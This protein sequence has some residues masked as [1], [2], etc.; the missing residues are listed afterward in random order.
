M[1]FKILKRQPMKLLALFLFWG[2]LAAA[3]LFFAL[4][5]WTDMRN[6]AYVKEY[7]AC[8]GTLIGKETLEDGSGRDKGALLPIKK[9]AVELLSQSDYVSRLDIRATRSAYCPELRNISGMFYGWD[10]E[11]LVILEGTVM[12]YDANEFEGMLHIRMSLEDPV[13]HSAHSEWKEHI[14]EEVPVKY[15][16]PLNEEI[17]FEPGDRLLIFGKMGLQETTGLTTYAVSI[18]HADSTFPQYKDQLAVVDQ[19]WYARALTKLERNA[20]PE[21]VQ[22]V[23]RDHGFEPFIKDAEILDHVFTVHMVSDMKLLLPITNNEMFYT[24][25]RGITPNDAGKK[26][27]VINNELAQRHSLQVGDSISLGLAEGCY[28][29]GEYLSGYPTLGCTLTM[30]YGDAQAYEIIG[31]YNFTE[32]NYS[33]DPFQYSY[34]GIF[35]PSAKDAPLAVEE[36]RPYTM[37]FQVPGENYD[38][39]LDITAPELEKLGYTVRL[40]NSKWLSV[41]TIYKNMEERRVGMLIAAVSTFLVCCTMYTLLLGTSYKKEF[42]LRKLL[43]TDSKKARRAYSVPFAL[44]TMLGSVASIG[45]V[46]VLYHRVMKAEIAKV[47]P[48]NVPNEITVLL[49]LLVVTLIQAA[50]CYVLLRLWSRYTE[51]SAVRK[52]LK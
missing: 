33:G 14:G 41:Q 34:N 12:S 32:Y 21:Q 47:A 43:G 29:T 31:T 4:Q 44:A 3:S 13:I 18:N 28:E 10:A 2:V 15:T 24:A 5:Y 7:Y 49:F 38:R 6:L 42:A 51:R 16:M 37:S 23:I 45:S 36:A 17:P 48:N 1:E 11:H 26:V 19:E 52:L 8:T 30:P 40:N 35:I 25:G 46:T 22:A 27:C 39:F 50:L 20:T 9:E